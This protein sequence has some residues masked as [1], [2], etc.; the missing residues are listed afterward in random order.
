MF[1]IIKKG[2]PPLFSRKDQKAGLSGHKTHFSQSTKHC[3]PTE[4]GG[5]RAAFRWLRKQACDYSGG[6]MRVKGKTHVSW[7][8]LCGGSFLAV[9]FMCCP[10]LRDDI[11]ICWACLLNWSGGITC[12]SSH[13]LVSCRSRIQLRYA[14]IFIFRD[15]NKSFEVST[16]DVC[17]SQLLN[18]RALN[19]GLGWLDRPVMFQLDLATKAFFRSYHRQKLETQTR[20]RK[21]PSVFVHLF[22]HLLHLNLPWKMV[23][24]AQEEHTA[25]GFL[26]GG[27]K[28]TWWKFEEGIVRKK[29]LDLRTKKQNLELGKSMMSLS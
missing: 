17:G 18:T 4:T 10:H 3:R 22:F 11:R 15:S 26:K 23:P 27:Y 29:I 28:F 5:G 24:H 25:L 19:E 20:P 2:E 16:R 9:L 13:S 1:W 21:R 12:L 7:V 14:V 8:F 6:K